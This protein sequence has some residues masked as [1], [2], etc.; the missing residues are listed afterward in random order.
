MDKLD[1]REWLLTNGLGSFACGTISD[2]RTRTYHGLMVAALNPPTRRQLLLAGIDASLDYQSSWYDLSTNHWGSGSISPS[3]YQLL[4]SFQ[5]YPIPTWIWGDQN[6]RI[7]RQL[8]M[9]YA[10]LDP[11][12]T[13]DSPKEGGAI[14]RQRLLLHYHYQ[15]ETAA[16]LKLRPIIGDRG[17]HHQQSGDEEVQFEQTTGDRQV[18]LQAIRPQQ[19]GTAWTLQWTAGDYTPDGVWYWDYCYPEETRR[20]LSDREDLYSPGYLTVPLE[21]GQSVTLEASLGNGS[22]L[23]LGDRSFNDA[24]HAERHRLDRQIE[25]M[26]ASGSPALSSALAPPVN[27]SRSEPGPA[28]P[29]EPEALSK[30]AALRQLLLAGD[31]FVVYRESVSGP[32]VL[33]GYPWFSDWGRDT[34]IS[35][36]GLALTTGRFTLAKG[37]LRTF[38]RY[39][40]YGLIP[41]S[42]PDVG[43]QPFYN[44]LDASLW[45]IETLG[46]YLETTRDWDFLIEQY[47][48]VQKIYKALTIG[49]LHNIRVDAVDGLLTWDTPHFAL[50]WM[51]AVV[52]NQ[53][54]TPR[55]GK[56]IEINALWYSSL[57]WASRW[58]SW[59]KIN[60][61]IPGIDRQ[62]RRYQQQA[63]QVSNSL[64]KY[65]NPRRGYFYDVIGPDDRPDDRIRPNAIVAL[66]LS[67]CSFS[68]HHGR[69]ALLLARDRLLTPYG[70]RSLD[71]AETDYVGQYAGNVAHRDLAYHQGSAWTWLL[72]PFIR[73]WQRFFPNDPLPLSLDLL[74]QHFDHD[75]C[76]GSISELFDG[77]PPHSP[78]GA[79][80]LAWSVA[81]LIRHW[82]DLEN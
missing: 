22:P 63:D 52:Q 54:V 14:A 17:F 33:A 81:E 8:L 3:G 74:L 49:T 67:H 73:G 46:L 43:S 24:L 30:A 41:N 80:A 32:T 50:T 39:C 58:T 15:G 60:A 28:D 31:Q 27:S 19:A 71:P 55:R 18:L 34:L 78:Q 47:P 36:P 62:A 10:W 25:R 7:T 9:P 75:G 59:L 40:E 82:S 11:P 56:P 72:G 16:L 1:Q 70:L 76:I 69:A 57:R 68:P 64:Q 35:L 20:G 38:A 79:I 26:R 53:P 23:T 37:L 77:D 51:D 65:W 5:R 45:W 61:D 42:F 29:D 12:D 6:W 21:P 13:D 4:Q 44:C 66:S 48:T 2:A